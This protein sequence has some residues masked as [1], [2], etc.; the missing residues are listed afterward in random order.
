[1]FS[2]DYIVSPTFSIFLG[3]LLGAGKME[4]NKT[5]S[6]LTEKVNIKNT[7]VKSTVK[8][9]CKSYVLTRVYQFGI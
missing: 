6:H 4:V 1:M 3:N 8:E 9:K 5:I 2:K 7:S